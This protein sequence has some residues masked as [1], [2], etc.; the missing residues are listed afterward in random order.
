MERNTSGRKGHAP[1]DRRDSITDSALPGKCAQVDDFVRGSS[2]RTTSSLALG[3]PGMVIERHSA[4]AAER[5]ERFS[6]HHILAVWETYS[7]QTE[8]RDSRGA[9]VRVTKNP[10]WIDFFPAG[11]LSPC[12]STGPSEMVVCAF[13]PEFA[14]GVEGELDFGSAGNLTEFSTAGDETLRN[15]V[16]MMAS[17]VEMKGAHGRLYADCLT[18]ALITHILFLVRGKRRDVYA[19]GLPN[20][21][22]QRVVSRMRADLATDITLSILAAECGYSRTH[23]LRMFRTATGYTP[24]QYLLHLRLQAARQMLK[25]RSRSLIEIAIDCGFSSHAHFSR[26]FRQVVGITPSAFRRNL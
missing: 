11:I 22:L 14:K 4:D 6:P 3:W 2:R 26:T 20:H 18:H 16:K 24:H 9:M 17:E 10:G 21:L 19:S 1:I 8:H 23:F 13:N 7:F 5:Q 12:R 25:Q 15:L